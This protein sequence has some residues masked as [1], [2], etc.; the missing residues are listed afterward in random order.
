MEIGVSSYLKKINK[1]LILS[2]IIKHG[3]ISR[4]DLANITKLTKATISGQVAD[5]LEEE[6][7]IETHKEYGSVGR[8]PIMLSLRPNAGYALGIDLDYRD[9]KFIV[10]D[11]MGNPVHTERVELENSNYDDIIHILINQIR[12]YQEKFSHSR[13]GIIGVVVGIHGTVTNDKTIS[14]VPQHRWYKKDI[15]ADIEKNINIAVYVENNANLCA[16]AEKVFNFHQCTNLISISMYSGIGLGFLINGDLVKGYHGFAG[17]MGHMIVYPNGKPCNCGKTGCWELYASEV[18]FF[19]QISQ[20]LD[21]PI[22]NYEDIKNLVIAKDPAVITEM[23]EYIKN[24]SIGL[25]NIIN[26]LNPETLVL[27][28]ELLKQ[29]PEAM[30]IIKSNIQTSI[31]NYKEIYIS[32]L[33]NDA[34]GMGA[35]ALAIKNFLEIPDLSLKV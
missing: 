30:S 34:C 22:L 20:K 16:F 17:E 4:S 13:F 18:S 10:S 2:K 29:F 23:D 9:I 26:L 1:S 33:G 31:S 35:C 6:L 15:K 27:N 25:N 8:K 7:I 3:P 21:K 28:S 19:K 32:D 5:L 12:A 14:F 24:V 11:L